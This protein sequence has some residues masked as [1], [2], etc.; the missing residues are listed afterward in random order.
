M[1]SETRIVKLEE[2]DHVFLLTFQSG[3][4]F[5]FIFK[6]FST[7][8]PTHPPTPI[9]FSQ[10]VVELLLALNI[11]VHRGRRYEL[12]T[13]D[14]FFSLLDTFSKAKCRSSNF[15]EKVS[16]VPSLLTKKCVVFTR[17]IFGICRK[18]R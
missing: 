14:P 13:G 9:T 6:I 2:F 1:F 17:H 12:W 8:P 3:H 4:T 18:L 7:L 5:C 11:T 16:Y 10:G 15:Y